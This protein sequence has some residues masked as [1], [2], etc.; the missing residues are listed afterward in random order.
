MI[1]TVFGTEGKINTSSFFYLSAYF[2][3]VSSR[4]KVQ[5]LWKVQLQDTHDESIKQQLVSE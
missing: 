5:K 2:V 1:V 4:N 3:H